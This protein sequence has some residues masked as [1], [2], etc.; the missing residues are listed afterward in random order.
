M[1]KRDPNVDIDIV[2]E[3][4]N[5]LNLPISLD[6][7]LRGK[8]V[9]WERLEYKA[10]WN[11]EAVLHTVCTFAFGALARSVRIKGAGSC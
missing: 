11:P 7:V 5:S 10:G 4:T 8:S 9:E 2:K 6:D 3:R 1:Q